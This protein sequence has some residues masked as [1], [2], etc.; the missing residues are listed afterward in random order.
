[1]YIL[2]FSTC[3]DNFLTS[4][5][6]SSTIPVIERKFSSVF[7]NCEFVSAFFFEYK[8]IPAA[9]SKIVL[10]SSGDVSTNHC[11]VP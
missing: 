11:T 7:S 10:L 9:S 4:A 3:L 6:S 1:V 2:A 8:P 5:F